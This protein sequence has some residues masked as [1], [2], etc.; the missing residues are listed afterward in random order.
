MPAIRLEFNNVKHV[1]HLIPSGIFH[2]EK[3]NIIG[4]GLVLDPAVF[5]NEI[6]ESRTAA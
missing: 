3:L 6:E 4:N 5:R 2:P 1:L